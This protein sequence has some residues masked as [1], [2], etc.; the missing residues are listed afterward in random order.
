MGGK[1]CFC[2]LGVAADL[3]TKKYPDKVKWT[4]H[5]MLTR[6]QINFN[7]FRSSTALPELLADKIG[8]SS[9][10]QLAVQLLND[11]QKLTFCEIADKIEN[12][13]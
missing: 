6:K 8:L 10:D 4:N 5:P 2:A 11:E 13:F 1:Q 9:L 7:G 12:E 3:L